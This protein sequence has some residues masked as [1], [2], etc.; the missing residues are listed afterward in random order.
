MKTICGPTYL[1]FINTKGTTLFFRCTY[2]LSPNLDI[3]D[4]HKEITEE[5]L[6]NLQLVH[7]NCTY[8]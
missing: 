8:Q 1:Y 5:Y 7:E 6:W 3:K 2:V 4:E